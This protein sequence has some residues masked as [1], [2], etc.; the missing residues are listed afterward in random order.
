MTRDQPPL[1]QNKVSCGNS[2]DSKANE[3]ADFLVVSQN[4][5]SKEST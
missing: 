2:Q 1:L 5:I 4:I 3:D